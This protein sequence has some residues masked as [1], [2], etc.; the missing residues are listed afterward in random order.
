MNLC[1]TCA[2]NTLGWTAAETQVIGQYLRA[3]R[4]W[5]IWETTSSQGLPLLGTQHHFETK[6]GA[7]Q[8]AAAIVDIPTTERLKWWD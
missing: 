5:A 7:L 8:Y 4:A 3:S 6:A 1:L 2:G